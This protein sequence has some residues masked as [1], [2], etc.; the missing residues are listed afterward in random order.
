MKKCHYREAATSMPV[1]GNLRI[2][3]DEDKEKKKE[4]EAD[5]DEDEDD[6]LLLFT[7]VF[8]CSLSTSSTIPTVSALESHASKQL[9]HRNPSK[10]RLN[11]KW[12]ECKTNDI[13]LQASLESH[14]HHDIYKMGSE[15]SLSLPDNMTRLKASK[16]QQHTPATSQSTATDSMR[17]I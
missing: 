9:Q 12:A 5:E 1:P 11:F 10:K 17:R 4:A 6:M 2:G 7:T 15:T 14:G 13:S 3:L 8:L 16:F